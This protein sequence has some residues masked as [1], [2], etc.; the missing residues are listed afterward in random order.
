M[1]KYK[2]YYKT[3]DTYG[4]AEYS[5]LTTTKNLSNMELIGHLFSNCHVNINHAIYIITEEE[6]NNSSNI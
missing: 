5:A 1:T 4:E 3:V 6:Y 2:Y